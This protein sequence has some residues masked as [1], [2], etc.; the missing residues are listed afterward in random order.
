MANTVG[1]ALYT[2][3][4]E[5][6]MPVGFMCFKGLKLH[7]SDIQTLLHTAPHTK[8]IIDHLGFFRQNVST[9][10]T[11]LSYKLNHLLQTTVL[12]CSAHNATF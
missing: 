8:A 3:A 11:C 7:Y 6:S 2:L 1:R 5:L 10:A 9:A 12:Q 4:G